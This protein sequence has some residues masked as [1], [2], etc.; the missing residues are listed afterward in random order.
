M[1][2]V[3]FYG[4]H[5]CTVG[6]RVCHWEAQSDW[7][8]SPCVQLNLLL[9]MVKMSSFTSWK[10]DV[11]W[12]VSKTYKIHHEPIKWLNIFIFLALGIKSSPQESLKHLW[13]HVCSIHATR[14]PSCRNPTDPNGGSCREDHRPMESAQQKL[15]GWV[16]FCC[17]IMGKPGTKFSSIC[18]L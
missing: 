2:L 13:S 9:S 4:L 6:T 1:G 10:L 16:V 5:C 3:E 12:Q 14:T 17:R 18:I 11:P 8:W 7:P 15:T